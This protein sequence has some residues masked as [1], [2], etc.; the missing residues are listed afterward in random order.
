MQ[1][2]TYF[3]MAIIVVNTPKPKMV[4]MESASSIE[5][6]YFVIFNLTQVHG[7]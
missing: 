4:D 1:Y 3:H 2:T 7:L 5:A 6:Q